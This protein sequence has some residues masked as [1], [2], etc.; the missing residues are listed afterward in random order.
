MDVGDAAVERIF[1]GDHRAV[2]AA[3]LYRIDRVFKAET[4][5]RD[6][7]GAH[8]F[9]RDVRIRAGCALE[10]HGT[11]GILRGGVHHLLNNVASGERIIFHDMALRLRLN[12]FPSK[13]WL[14]V[15]NLRL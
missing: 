2:G 5:H 12:Y 13:A 11:R 3:F 8:L 14:A 15:M 10:G 6:R 9:D 7:I 1:D 4:G